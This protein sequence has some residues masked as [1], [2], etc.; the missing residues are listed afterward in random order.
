VKHRITTKTDCSF[1]YT[2]AVVVLIIS[3]HVSLHRL[4]INLHIKLGSKTNKRN[5]TKNE[6]IAYLRSIVFDLIHSC[7]HRLKMSSFSLK[8]NKFRSIDM[9][10]WRSTKPLRLLKFL[11]SLN[12]S[13]WKDFWSKGDSS[14]L[15]NSPPFQLSYTWSDVFRVNKN[16]IQQLTAMFTRRDGK[17]GKLSDQA[18]KML[19]SPPGAVNIASYKELLDQS[20]C[21][22]FFVQL[23]NYTR[24][25]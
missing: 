11:N 3:F 7:H 25:Y 1:A 23:W 10:W 21:W 8:K 20:D 13:F 22:K 2:H 17:G 6:F 5:T 16:L 15:K 19:Y 14:R 24:C 9:T 4:W 18:S 12:T